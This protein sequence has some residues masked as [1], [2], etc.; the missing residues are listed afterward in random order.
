MSAVKQTRI[1]GFALILFLFLLP[2][3]ASAQDFTINEFNARIVINEDA[4]C[5]V[6][7]TITVEFHRPRHGIYREIPYV[8][9]DSSGFTTRTP[10]EILSVTDGS[11]SA[12]QTKITREGSIVRIRIGDPDKYVSGVQTYE[13][14]YTVENAVLFFDGHDELY[15]NVTGNYWHSDIKKSQVSVSLDGRQSRQLKASCYTGRSGSKE[16][17]CTFEMAEN[18]V[19]FDLQKQLFSGEGFTI[20][21]GWDKGIVSPPSSWKKFLWLINL[22]QN[23]V[24]SLPLLSLAIMLNLWFKAGRDPAARHAVTVMYEPPKYKGMPLCPA[25]VGAMVDEKLDSRDITATIIGLAVK[26]YIR[27]EESKKDGLI[28]DTT[29][30]YLKKIKEPD[31]ALSPFEMQ[32]MSDVFGGLPGKMIS[33][34]RNNFYTRIDPLKKILYSNLVRKNFFSVSPDKVRQAYAASG[35]L[36]TIAIILLLNVSLADSIGSVRAFLSGILSGLP[37]LGFSRFMPAKT[38]SGASVYYDVLGFQEFLNRAEK[39]RLIRMK[40]ENLFSKFFP[41]ALALDVA[42]NWA[43]AFEGIYQQTPEWYVSPAGFRTFNPVVFSRSVTPALSSLSSAMFSSPRGSGIG[44][45][46]FSGG[47]SSGGGFGGGGGG[48]W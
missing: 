38:K 33:D 19:R 6:R 21:F 2:L 14:L 39:D 47:G 41:Y 9:T 17:A 28:F 26:G 10:L 48:S 4:S 12:R 42:D 5:T 1:I 44:G 15:W 27:I 23:W 24:F 20:A 40:D 35:F 16:T 29:D 34:L 18:F 45:G 36:V 46:G 25:E 11:A 3:T 13:I 8:Y 43:R 32:L 22:E 7:E 37:V 30:Y 31:A